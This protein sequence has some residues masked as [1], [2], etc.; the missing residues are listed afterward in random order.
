MTTFDLFAQIESNK[1]GIIYD[2]GYNFNYT[3]EKLMF[4][5]SPNMIMV[6][7][8]FYKAKMWMRFLKLLSHHKIV[9]SQYTIAYSA[10]DSHTCMAQ[11]ME[12]NKTTTAATTTTVQIKLYQNR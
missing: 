7:L 10:F 6:R 12:K 8:H 5:I 1:N 4:N 2:F 9:C 11:V 3:F